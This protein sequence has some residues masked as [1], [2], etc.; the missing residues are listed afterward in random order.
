MDKSQI[1]LFLMSAMEKFPTAHLGI[2]RMQLEALDNE[3]MMVFSS[4]P[5]KEPQTATI[6]AFTCAC[7]RLYLDDI[8][9]GILKLVLILF[10]VGF[11]WWV[12][13][14]FTAADR[15]REHNLKLFSQQMVIHSFS[16]QP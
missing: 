1:D 10:V 2:M 6:L 7:D 12:I 11:I 8:G 4:L 9:L 16:S 13:D 3:K 5:Y 14:I 15:A